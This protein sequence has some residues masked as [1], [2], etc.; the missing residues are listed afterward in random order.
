MNDLGIRTVV[1]PIDDS[2]GAER[3]LPHAQFLATKLDAG[4][5]LLAIADTPDRGRHLQHALDHAHAQLVGQLGDTRVAYDFWTAE[6]IVAATTPNH[7]VACIATHWSAGRSIARRVVFGSDGPVLLVGP[8][9]TPRPDT[10][11]T[12]VT[13]SSDHPASRPLVRTAS[14]WADALGLSITL[15][16]DP[17]D[18]LL[19]Y[20]RHEA[21]TMI[22]AAVPAGWGRRLSASARAASRLIRA[23]HAPILA[24]PHR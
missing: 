8:R 11:G 22:A 9:A 10:A 14:S 21:V 17:S 5:H 18:A 4:I 24:V 3:A 23:A 12:V 20:E 1:V 15:L 2:D 13:V 19:E 16:A 7:A 6:H